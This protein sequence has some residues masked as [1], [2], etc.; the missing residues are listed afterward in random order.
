MTPTSVLHIPKKF[1][2]ILAENLNILLF[3]HNH[4]IWGNR[5]IEHYFHELTYITANT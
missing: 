2:K 4:T 1:S 5:L 3:S